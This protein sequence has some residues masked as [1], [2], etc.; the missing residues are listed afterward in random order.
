MVKG[1]SRPGGG[2]GAGEDLIVL[3]G[4][5]DLAAIGPGGQAWVTERFCL[6]DL[7]ITAADAA[8]IRCAGDFLEGTENFAVHARTGQLCEGRRFADNWPGR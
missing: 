3:A 2:C 6:D 7:R 8:T 4:F 1:K 5:F